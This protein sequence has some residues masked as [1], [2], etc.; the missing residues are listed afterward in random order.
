MKKN[1]TKMFTVSLLFCFAMK[2]NA[3]WQLTGNANATAAS[4]LG[5][6]N[7]ISLNLMTKNTKR[8][9]IDTLGRIGIGTTTPVNILTV[10]GAGSIPAANWVASGSPLFVG[11]GETAVGNA[12]YILSMASTSNNG[13]PVFVG[14]R[15]RGSLA[16]PT[17]M[18]NNDFIM[19][20][21]ASGYDGTTFQNPATIDF[22]VDGTPSA[23]NVPARISFVTGSNS[24]N[25]AERLKVGSTGD[26][27]FN[28]NQLFVQQSTGNV[29]IGSINPSA[30]LE[31]VGQVKITGGSPGA[32]KV[33]TSNAVGLATWSSNGLL[34]AGLGGQTLRNN[35]LAWVPSYMIMNTG[36]QVGIGETNP[37]GV[38]HVS[39]PFNFS[40]V[41]FTGTGLNDLTAD[42][43]G[44]SGSGTASY[45]IRIQNAGPNPN[46]IEISNDGG[47]TFGAPVP[48]N[49]P[50]VLAN[51]VSAS[52]AALTG[53]T[54][55][56]Q[57]TWNIGIAYK[58]M[59]VAKD[60]KVGIGTTTPSALLD[61]NGVS[62]AKSFVA[63]DTSMFGQIGVAGP[64]QSN[65]AINLNAKA[66]LAGINVT[67]PVGNY[68]LYCSNKSGASSAI[69][70][71]KT[72]RNTSTAVVLGYAAGSGGGIEGDAHLGVGTYGYSD[73]SFGV[74]GY[75]GNAN[76]YAGY[77]SGNVFATGTYT[78]SDARLKK[79]IRDFDGGLEMINKLHPK[80]YTFRNDGWYGKMNLPTG[81]HIGIMAQ[82]L[83]KVL[84]EAVKESSINT[85]YLSKTRGDGKEQGPG[86][87]IDFKAVNYVELIPVMIKGMQE[88]SAKNEELTAAN[89]KLV[90]QNADQQTLNQSLETRLSKLEAVMNTG[91]QQNINL[92]SASLEQ[93][94]PNPPV[95]NATKINYNIPSSAAK[96]EMIIT[97]VYGKKVKQINLNNSGKGTVNINTT[98]L[99]AGTYSYTLFVDGKMIETKKMVVAGN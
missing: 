67:D 38:L 88:L 93:N 41:S 52:F 40:G 36:S 14:R 56:D 34:P 75:A 97:D 44:F 94:I 53:H 85:N 78:A 92:S 32:G 33:L 63:T 71:T 84:P 17:I 74:Y 3:Q 69:Y 23:G 2:S 26:I 61:V 37:Q 90:K 70:I 96:A 10:K 18:A 29:S 15:S 20:M 83:E 73:S 89:D 11:Y 9:T 13:R 22:F 19:S 82:E 46:I 5:T 81:T 51:G 30:K 99:A 72:S 8:F 16:V 91:K 62:K 66:A 48:I 64:T 6:T 98:G 54:F 45:V 86:E 43:S 77:F 76:S 35:S 27:A 28:S 47:A 4:V 39:Q 50:I 59:L 1:L 95:N 12:D 24:S 49:N 7:S 25:R 60:G 42:V 31:V 58:D 68:I 21:L 55:A 65:Y 80:S 79:N 87:N 57:W